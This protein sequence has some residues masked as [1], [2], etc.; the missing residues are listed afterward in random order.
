MTNPGINLLYADSLSNLNISFF[1]FH[2]KMNLQKEYILQTLKLRVGNFD[3]VF[4]VCSINFQIFAWRS[5]RFKSFCLLIF[6]CTTII[7][8][9]ISPPPFYN[10]YKFNLKST[11]GYEWRQWKKTYLFRRLIVSDCLNFIDSFHEKQRSHLH[12]DQRIFLRPGRKIPGWY[13]LW[14][15]QWRKR[16]WSVEV[17]K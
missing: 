7:A 14:C 13:R 2:S 8:S 3:L 10:T 16:K 15:C 6:R 5:R 4:H 17:G 11:N 9:G 1:S 12:S